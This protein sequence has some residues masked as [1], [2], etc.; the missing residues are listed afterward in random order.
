[1]LAASICFFGGVEVR[2][3]ELYYDGML[4]DA[5]EPLYIDDGTT[6]VSART[7]IGMNR[8]VEARWDGVS[9][10]FASDK[11]EVTAVPGELYI[12]VNGERISMNKAVS[13]VSSRV[14][15]PVRA[16]AAALGASVEYDGEHERITLKSVKGEADTDKIDKDELYW[17]SRII[18][19]ESCGEPYVGKLLVGNVVLNRRD[20]AQFPNTVKEVIFDTT[21]GVQF[22]PISNGSIYVAPCESCIAAAREVLAGKVISDSALYFVNTSKSPNSWAQLNRPFIMRV[23]EHSFYE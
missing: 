9:A 7:L 11:L 20:S 12:K 22:T 6:F 8:S 13:L 23:G 19:A 1:M 16:L 18:N 21:Y 3:L 5:S 17:L 15:V 14:C 2:S 10:Y 4:Y